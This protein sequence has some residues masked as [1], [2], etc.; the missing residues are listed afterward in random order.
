M[1]KLITVLTLVSAALALPLTSYDE[2]EKA[3]NA[4]IAAGTPE[5]AC[6]CALTACVG[7]DSARIREYCSSATAS[8]AQPTKTEI[9]SASKNDT[10]PV[11]TFT[12]IPGIPGGCNPA[13]PGSCSP[14]YHTGLPPTF[15][16]IPI[17]PGGCSPAHPELCVSAHITY[18]VTSAATHPSFPVPTNGVQPVPGIYP[19]PMP[20]VG[21]TWAIQNLTRYCG[22]DGDGCD[23]NFIV[24]ADGKTER[25][26]IIRMPGSNAATESWA[27]EPCTD[28]SNLRISWG[29]VTEPV[30]AFA[31]ITAVRDKELAWFGVS[32][33]NGQQVTSSN[34]YGSGDYGTLGPEQVYTY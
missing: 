7:E 8:L 25:C 6:S 34:P 28:G 11:E 29:Y 10:V 15:T 1:N 24:E 30:P 5:V 14:P 20:I 9:P 32:D 31:V 33:V 16:P 17:V 23:Y 12:P 19:G 21:K 26:T 22:E 18:T 13:H 4:C 2:C 27:N 3:Y